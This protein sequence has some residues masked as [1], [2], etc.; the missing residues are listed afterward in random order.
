M[1]DEARVEDERPKSSALADAERRLQQLERTVAA[2]EQ[3][4]GADRGSLLADISRKL[5]TTT[6]APRKNQGRW[7]AGARSTH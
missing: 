1:T 4:A 6:R 5:A 2:L 7:R 3:L